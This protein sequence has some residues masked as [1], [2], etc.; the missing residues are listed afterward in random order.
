MKN[1][2]IFDKHP[3]EKTRLKIS[4]N[5]VGINMVCQNRIKERLIKY[6]SFI[7]KIENAH[8]LPVY[9]SSWQLNTI[10]LSGEYCI[11][12][13]YCI[14][15]PATLLCLSLARTWNSNSMC[16]GLL[17]VQLS[18]GERWFYP[19]VDIGGIVDHHC[20]SFYFHNWWAIISHCSIQS[21]IFTSLYWFYSSS[22]DR[23]RIR[24]G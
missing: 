3:L 11:Q 23:L 9:F 13:L 20:L 14:F 2:F 12:I 6:L 24:Y 22:N 18:L 4:Q 8:K 15:S 1:R 16:D 19:F 21:D 17:C 10:F 5:S 7:I